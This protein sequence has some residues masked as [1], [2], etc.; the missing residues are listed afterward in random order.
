[1]AV[2]VIAL[3]L[4]L[5]VVIQGMATIIGKIKGASKDDKVAAI[6]EALPESVA[7]AEFVLD[8]D[9]FNDSEIRRLATALAKI[10]TEAAEVRAALKAAIVAKAA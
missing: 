5:P 1:M 8:R 6:I 4:K 7:L 10:E 9:L 2:N 3:A